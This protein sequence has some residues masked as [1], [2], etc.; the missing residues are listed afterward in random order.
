MHELPLGKINQEYVEGFKQFSHLT[1][2]E[3]I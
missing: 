3:K 1:K 2:K